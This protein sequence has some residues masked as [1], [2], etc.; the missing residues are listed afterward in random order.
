M[1]D[2]EI[3]KIE[4][5]FL[6][7]S[8][9]VRHGHQDGQGRHLCTIYGH[10]NPAKGVR[11]GNR[12]GQGEIIA[13]LTEVERSAANVFPHLHLTVA[14]VSRAFA[15]DLLNWDA[16]NHPGVATLLDPL[17]AMN[18]RHTTLDPNGEPK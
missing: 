5:D 8:V 4:E 13:T 3:I 18:C 2:G 12:L 6:G 9:F 11:A 15:P 1:F 17:R 14:W 7:A 16:L 10:T